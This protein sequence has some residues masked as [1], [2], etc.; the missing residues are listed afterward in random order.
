MPCTRS[1]GRTAWVRSPDGVLCVGGVAVTDLAEQ[2]GT[3]A[4][5]VDEA[6]FRGRARSSSA[7]STPRSSSSTLCRRGRLLRGQGVPVHRDRPVGP[8]GGPM[9]R[10][11]QLGEL[12]VA[13]RAG[14]PGARIGMHG[15]N[16]SVA[17]LRAASITAS[18]GSSST[19][20]TRS[21]GSPPL[22][23]ELGRRR[24]GHGP[25]HRGCRGAHPRVHRDRAR[26]PE[27]RFQP[28]RRCR[29]RR[30]CWPSSHVDPTS[31][32]RPAQPHRL[33]D[34]RHLRLRGVGPADPAN[35]T[36]RSPASTASSCRRWTSAVAIG[37][38][39]TSEHTP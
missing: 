9:P 28:G 5:V 22:P 2:F 21:T 25:G 34:L 15:N 36:P 38:A 6:D 27:V 10:R 11:V 12:S 32:A 26:G 19:P 3:P 39:Y 33:A 24:A 7:T 16:K 37:I 17:E 8:R 35:C 1:S 31:A 20:S 13:M 4:Y 30:P 14:F 18:G 29:P 23:L